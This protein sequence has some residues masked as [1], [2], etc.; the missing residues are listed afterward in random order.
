MEKNSLA[1]YGWII[2]VLI[3][4]LTVLTIVSPIGDKLKT[5]LYKNTNQLMDVAEV[6]P[7]FTVSINPSTYGTCTVEKEKVA[8]DDTVE[9][10]CEPYSGHAYNGAVIRSESGDEIL[11]LPASEKSFKMPSKNVV[12][13][14]IYS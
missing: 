4:L 8:E 12:V 3:I 10:L 5:T 1:T 6:K 13:T 7:V 2:V 14:V 11:S 9:L